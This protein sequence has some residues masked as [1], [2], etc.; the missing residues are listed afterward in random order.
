MHKMT[1]EQFVIPDGK[2]ALRDGKLSED[3]LKIPTAKVGTLST[4]G[5]NS[6]S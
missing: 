5:N 2:E 3:R 6:C 1:L 4:K